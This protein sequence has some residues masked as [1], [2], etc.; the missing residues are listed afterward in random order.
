MAQQ[1]GCHDDGSQNALTIQSALREHANSIRQL[2]RGAVSVDCFCCQQGVTAQQEPDNDGDSAFRQLLI[3]RVLAH[4][5]AGNLEIQFLTFSSVGWG[6]QHWSPANGNSIDVHWQRTPIEQQ[7]LLWSCQPSCWRKRGEVYELE[8]AVIDLGR[9]GHTLAQ[10]SIPIHGDNLYPNQDCTCFAWQSHPS[11]IKLTRMLELEDGASIQLD[12][13]SLPGVFDRSEGRMVYIG[14]KLS[15]W[16][17]GELPCN[18]RPCSHDTGLQARTS[19]KLPV[20]SQAVLSPSGKLLL[21]GPQ[22]ASPLSVIIVSK[23]SPCSMIS[24]L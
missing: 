23:G 2:C 13:P 8:L 5:L 7:R 15:Q 3:P 16:G 14:H 10:R 18:P 1:A 11:L 9:P 12:E 24:S 20:S 22:I 6:S 17:A 19:L 4:W 21:G